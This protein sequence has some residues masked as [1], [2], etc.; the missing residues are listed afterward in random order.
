MAKNAIQTDRPR[1]KH[2]A[3][4]PRITVSHHMPLVSTED[5][6]WPIEAFAHIDEL[7]V[8]IDW[9]RGEWNP[10]FAHAERRLLEA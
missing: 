3:H 5:L 8:Q 9:N 2:H 6:I 1:R 10:M 7:G 4:I